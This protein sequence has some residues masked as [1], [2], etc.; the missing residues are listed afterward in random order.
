MSD[1]LYRDRLFDLVRAQEQLRQAEALAQ[2]AASLIAELGVHQG[3]DFKIEIGLALDAR[4][5]CYDAVEH[6]GR[7]LHLAVGL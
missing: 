2:S 7:Q 6:L 5:R 3:L 1:T 4:R